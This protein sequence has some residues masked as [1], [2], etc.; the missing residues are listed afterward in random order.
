[1]RSRNVSVACFGRRLRARQRRRLWRPPCDA[2]T[3]LWHLFHALG[4][5]APCRR[6]NCELQ[7][8]HGRGGQER[9]L[10]PLATKTEGPA[11]RRAGAG[12]DRPTRSGQPRLTSNLVGSGISELRINYGP[13][14]RIY[15]LRDGDT[16]ILLLCGGDKS[17]QDADIKTAQRI[18]TSWREENKDE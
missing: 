11:R 7:L 12:A 3:S 8:T 6:S 13:G 14:Y 2:V 16:L 15:Y 5:C 18:A 17:S 10:R 1:M 9:D 4:A